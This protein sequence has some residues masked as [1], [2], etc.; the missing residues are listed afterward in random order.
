MG[1]A[2]APAKV[3]KNELKNLGFTKL[4]MQR[5]RC[6]AMWPKSVKL[7]IMCKHMIDLS[8]NQILPVAFYFGLV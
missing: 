6:L 3:V 7:N 8:H 2:E 4:G 1:A 5:N